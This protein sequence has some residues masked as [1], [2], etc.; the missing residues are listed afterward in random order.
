MGASAKPRPVWLAL[1]WAERLAI[2]ALY[3]W[4]ASKVMA[5]ALSGHW[6]DGLLLA[7]E[8]ALVVFVL[9]RRHTEHVSRKPHE[10]LLAAAATTGPLLVAPSGEPLIAGAVCGALMFLGLLV[11]VSAKVTLA[12]SFGIVPANRGVKIEGPYRFVRHPMYAG[13]LLTHVGFL[14]AHPTA[15]NAAVY[16]VSLGLQVMRLLAEERLLGQDPKYVAFRG[17]VRWRLAPG[18]F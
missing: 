14:L 6:Y 9:L 16:A 12:R 7:S 3:A 11:Q 15:W 5:S 4:F 8:T 13:Y 10:W 18:I 2:A 1:D 17:S